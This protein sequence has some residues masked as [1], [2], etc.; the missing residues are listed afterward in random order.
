MG[1]GTMVPAPE[2]TICTRLHDEPHLL[3]RGSWRALPW[4]ASGCLPFLACL[5]RAC[6]EGCASQAKVGVSS[7]SEPSE[8]ALTL[9]SPH[10]VGS[11]PLE[12]R[13]SRATSGNSLRPLPIPCEVSA[14]AL[15]GWQPELGEEEPLLGEER[16]RPE[17]SS[18]DVRLPS[19]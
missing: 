16:T 13:A 17:G 4:V 6:Y 9:L 5:F 8:P 15:P 7:E 1:R 18:S 14:H 2:L 3:G 11:T 12:T 10:S 19:S